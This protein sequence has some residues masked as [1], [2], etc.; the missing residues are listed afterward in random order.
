MEN[1]KHRLFN[2]VMSSLDIPLLNDKLVYI[3]KELKC[4]AKANLAFGFVHKNLEDGMFR[5]FYAH[6]NNTILKRSKLVCTKAVMT[7]LKIRRQKM[8]S[9]D[10]CTRERAKTKWIFYTN[11]QS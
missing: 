4:A 6:E 3:F 10:F 11:L 9:V 2:F 8:D 5:Y 7:N 1:R